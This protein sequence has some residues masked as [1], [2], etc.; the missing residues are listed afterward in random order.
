MAVVKDGTR[1]ALC[2][3]VQNCVEPHSTVRTD[4]WQGYR[5]LVHRGYTHD[6]VLQHRNI[7]EASE[8]L[9][10]VHRV[11]SL[12]K[13][14]LLGTHQGSVSAAHL[15]Y[16]LDEFTFRFNRRKSKAR[17]KLFYRLVEQAVAIEPT[18]YKN[19]IHGNYNIWYPLE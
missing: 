3:F 11:A 12:L 14:W 16:Y 5:D 2:G 13:R 17:G 7:K 1:D 15:P 18:P 8:L 9:P 6:R 4:G 10:G 19:L